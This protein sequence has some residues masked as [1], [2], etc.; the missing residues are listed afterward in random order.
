MD[1]ATRSAV[2]LRADNRCEYCRLRQEHAPLVQFQTEHIVPRQ[3]G[4]GDELANLCLACQRCNLHKGPNLTGIDEQT[5]QII[6]LFN[7]RVQRWEDHFT[8]RDLLIVGLT[9]VGR[10]TVRLLSMNSLQ[11]IELRSQLQ[12]DG[13]WP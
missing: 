6:V 2:R 3:H 7:P 8:I 9:S 11:R 13:F 4:G 12:E 5:G 10:A 1:A